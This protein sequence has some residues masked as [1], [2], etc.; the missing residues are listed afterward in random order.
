MSM[1]TL[2]FVL[3]LPAQNYPLPFPQDGAPQE[4]TWQGMRARFAP[5]GR[6]HREEV[7]SGSPRG[8]IIEIK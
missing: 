1:K 3:L 2:G 7:V 6:I 4:T 5:R 8:I